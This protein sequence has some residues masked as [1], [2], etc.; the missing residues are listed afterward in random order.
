[1]R[2][3]QNNE[4]QNQHQQLPEARKFSIVLYLQQR[5]VL[6]CLMAKNQR[7]FSIVLP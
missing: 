7:V 3:N 4:D 5:I 2:L 6:L 1:M